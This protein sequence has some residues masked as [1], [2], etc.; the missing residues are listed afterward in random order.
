MKIKTITAAAVMSLTCLLHG[1]DLKTV[2]LVPVKFEKAPA[3]APV[4]MISNGKLNFAIVADLNAEKRMQKKNRTQKSIE[5]AILII[6]E[7]IEK[8]T[9]ITPEILDVKDA[10]KAKYMIVVGDCSITRQNGIDVSKL[11]TQGL[12]IKTF[13]KGIIVAGHDSSLVEGYNKHPLDQKGSSLGTKYAAYDFVER[14][15]GVRYYF[16]G[17]YGTLWPEIRELTLKPAYYTDAPYF[18]Y[19]FGVYQLGESI[20]TKNSRKFWEKYLGKLTDR[21]VR[22]WNRWR[23]GYIDPPAGSH[24][25][26]PDRLAKAYPDK[27][28]T[29][30]YKS[31]SGNL[32]YNTKAH[33]GNY[34]D[35]V[36]L[37]FAD[38][39]IES[40]KK[41]YKSNGKINEAGF[42][43]CN[44]SFFSF[45]MCDTLLPETEV[46]HHPTVKKLG[47]MT[48]KDI[49]RGNNAGMANIYARFHQYLANR[50]QKEFP[51]VKLYILAYYNALYAG[52]DPRWKLPPNTEVNLCIGT[53]PNYVRNKKAAEKALKIAKEWYE[54]LGNRPVQK[55]WLYGS[56]NPYVQTVNGEFVGDIPKLYGKYLGRNALYF[57]HSS[58]YPGT[59]WFHYFSSYAA[60]RSMWNPD[61]DA[62]A[63]IDAHWENFYGKEVGK[64]LCEFH[65][66]LRYC[67]MKYVINGPADNKTI[68]YPVTEINKLEAMLEK[69]RKAV[70][71]G[72]VIEK[73]F[74]LVAAP[75]KKAFESTRN[76][77]TYDRPIHNAYQLLNGEK[78]VIDGAGTEKFWS[79]AQNLKL[80]DPNGSNTPVKFPA[81]I[82]FAWD[83]DGLYGLFTTKHSPIL[84]DNKKSL[85]VNDNF[86]LFLS[87]GLKKEVKFQFAFDALNQTFTGTQRL[88]PILQPFDRYWKA[89]GFKVACKYGK[90]FYTAEFFIPFKALGVKTP[91]AYSTWLCNAVRN[92]NSM[93]REYSGSSMTLGNN[94]NMDMYGILKFAGK[95]E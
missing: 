64:H 2:E 61:W 83:K 33:V 27:L 87:P 38:L 69:A 74:Q 76:Q 11:P 13:E 63:A 60:F 65:K 58:D 46:I 24:S 51:G 78:A 79:K 75:W 4:S 77:L 12:A 48:Q 5:P 93:P 68:A 49:A 90:D 70:K 10:A 16:P 17:E 91:R 89:P 15:L 1:Y 53:M 81:E 37:E 31:P 36:N 23:M 3:H 73:R 43:G 85:F 28:E 84:A 18:D 62:A 14:F 39:L 41:Y 32:W 21:N 66:H 82:K 42:T 7:A 56:K 22:F 67:Y 95:G 55:M 92:K 44:N 29:I 71:P 52:N 54:S 40:A 30:F 8:C 57:D 20:R 9:G 45:G 35:V 80:I 47:L 25:P 19:R 50:L 59:F 72:T 26:R 86:E 88:L 6:K 94:H 34:Y